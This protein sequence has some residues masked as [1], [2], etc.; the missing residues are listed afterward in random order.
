MCHSRP[1]ILGYPCSRSLELM[2]LILWHWLFIFSNLASFS[3]SLSSDGF[4][5][6]ALSKRLILPD[7]I[8]SNWSSHDTTPCGWKGVQ[9]EMNNVVDLNLS[10]YK[11]SGSI[12]PEVGHLRYLKQLDL[13]ST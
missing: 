5:L 8:S 2:G 1:L 10:Y 4:T 3:C 13:S 9:C 7:I 12:G 11:V 6:L